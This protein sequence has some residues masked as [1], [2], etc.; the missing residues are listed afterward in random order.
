MTLGDGAWARVIEMELDMEIGL[1]KKY[2]S[3]C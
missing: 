2:K 3:C 1:E